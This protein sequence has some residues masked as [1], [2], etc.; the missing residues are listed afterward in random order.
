MKS[1]A[2]PVLR[3]E[4]RPALLV[5]VPTDSERARGGPGVVGDELYPAV[6]VLGRVVMAHALHHHERR[7]GD[8]V[9]GMD[10]ATDVDERVAV[11]VEHERRYGDR[12]QRVV[13]A[14]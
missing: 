3:C 11:A 4:C 14:R 13:A 5:T 7:A 1:R 12:A 10:A 9:R 6:P 2:G 8:H